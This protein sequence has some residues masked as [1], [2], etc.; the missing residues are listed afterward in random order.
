V[1]PQI[2]T[3]LRISDISDV[4]APTLGEFRADLAKYALSGVAYI[5]SV[6]NAGLRHWQGNKDNEGHDKLLRDAFPADLANYIIRRCNDPANPRAVFHRRQFLFVMKQ[7]LEVC[8]STGLEPTAS[9]YW[10]GLGRMFLAANDLLRATSSSGA[11]IKDQMPAVISD[12]IPITEACG[13]HQPLN[14]VIRGY[15]LW[16]RFMPDQEKRK[17]ADIFKC[18]TGIPVTTYQALAL[19]SSTKYVNLDS[20]AFAS[21]PQSFPLSENWF[22]RMTLPAEHVNGFLEDVSAHPDQFKEFLATRNTG[23]DDFTFLRNKPFF[24]HG[25][26][27]FPIDVGFALE[28]FETG[29]FWTVH[30]HLDPKARIQLHASWG[31]AFESYVNWL[32]SQ[33]SGTDKNTI[34]QNPHFS[35]GDELCDTVIICG[36]SAIFIETKGSTFTAKSKYGGSPE[37]LKSEIDEKLVGTSKG[38][39]KG[40]RQLA[41]AIARVFGGKESVENLDFSRIDKVFPLIITRDDLGGGLVVN[42]YLAGKFREALSRKVSRRVT[43]TPLFSLSSQDLESIS[44]YLRDISLSS[45]LEA[46]YAHDPQL[47][48]TFWAVENDLI[49][50]LGYRRPDVLKPV[51]EEIIQAVK[52][53]LFPEGERDLS[54]SKAQRHLTSAP[55]TSL[56]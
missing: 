17:F 5:C 19:A 1:P 35:N 36:K 24:R 12:F 14:K 3:Y 54:D 9:P 4:P 47:L 31:K 27:L 46:R 33:S 16:N 48:S 29:P 39:K 7:A 44:S 51:Y 56:T 32:I 23:L 22:R 28:K 53:D 25:D 37:T 38:E 10:G 34:Y 30:G 26:Q 52:N 13:F 50:R 6:A 18:T 20:K 49:R 15:L 2:V 8:G 45:L 55:S 42:A 41:D 11:S 40:V 21:D 43:I